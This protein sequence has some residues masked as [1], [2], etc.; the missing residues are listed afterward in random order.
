MKLNDDDNYERASESEELDT[1]EEGD[2]NCRKAL[3]PTRFQLVN[4]GKIVPDDVPRGGDE[5]IDD[6]IESIE[7]GTPLL[8]PITLRPVPGA[9]KFQIIAGRRR[10]RLARLK[11]WSH[12]PATIVEADDVS[13]EI[14]RWTENVYRKDLDDRPAAIARLRALIEMTQPTERGG[15]R[16]SKKFQEAQRH[17]GNSNGTS[18]KR[19]ARLT[20]TSTRTVY[21]DSKIAEH[22]T[23]ML[24]Q[25]VNDG[26]IGKSKGEKIAGLAAAE[27]DRL[28]SQIIREKTTAP[29]TGW[30]VEVH[31]VL[32]SLE[33]AE[34]LT[35]KHASKM[36]V[37]AAKQIHKHATTIS[38][39]VA[40]RAGVKRRA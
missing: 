34:R 12:V 19:V 39:L 11:G 38:K 24:N 7:D 2:S 5:G 33:H 20:G 31:R 17:G 9:D 13:A 16:R 15:D 27:Q 22:G 1:I 18:A 36:P 26:V 25:A 23:S 8:H 28:V 32:E 35:H 29:A 21:R 6:L 40:S 10:L 14:M 30:Q 37:G 4:V 3:P